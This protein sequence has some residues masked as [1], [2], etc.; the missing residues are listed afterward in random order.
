MY[1]SILFQLTKLFQFSA[2]KSTFTYVIIDSH[3][4]NWNKLVNWNDIEELIQFQLYNNL[5]VW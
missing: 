4:L 3:A 2:C 1:S 5:S